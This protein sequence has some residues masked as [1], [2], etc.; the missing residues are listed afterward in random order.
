VAVRVPATA[1]RTPLTRERVLR[2]AIELADTDGVDALSMRR[3]GQALGVEAMS[4]YHHVASKADLLNGI[5]D[6]VTEEIELPKD[7]AA[8]KPALRSTAISAH[9]VFLKHPWA[10]NLTLS[11]GTGAGRYRYMEAI[12]RSLREG[13]FS[14]EM[15][16]HAYHA[17]ESHIVGFTLWV[18]GISASLA[19]IGEEQLESIVKEFESTYPYL[20]E[21][22]AEHGRERRPGDRT[23][24]EFG[25]DLILDGLEGMLG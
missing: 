12:L 21:H 7:G 4:L 11:A 8:W 9:R 18:V 17:L 5:L 3:L 25:L 2:E 10:A 19:T 23:E 15:T 24:F 6:L 14:A 1:T 13:G 20:A 16:H 22:A